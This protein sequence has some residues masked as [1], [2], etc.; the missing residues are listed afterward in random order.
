MPQDFDPQFNREGFTGTLESQFF[1]QL[2]HRM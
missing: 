2:I 1:S